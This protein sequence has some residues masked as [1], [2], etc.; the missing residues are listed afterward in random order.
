MREMFKAE[1]LEHHYRV[2]EP[3]MH[4]HAP[5]SLRNALRSVQALL[6]KDGS[7]VL[8]TV[9][10]ALLDADPLAREKVSSWGAWE[11]VRQGMGAIDGTLFDWTISHCVE[12]ER[13][14]AKAEELIGGGDFRGA[15][16]SVRS[17]DILGA[18]MTDRM[19]VDLA[20][21][22]S[23]ADSVRSRA[24]AMFEFQLSQV[25]S[26]EV[27]LQAERALLKVGGFLP[28]LVPAKNGRCRPGG[29]FLRWLQHRRSLP[30]IKSVLDYSAVRSKAGYSPVN[31]ATLKRW[32]SGTSFP[33]LEKLKALVRALA[34]AP[35]GEEPDALE[36]E[37]A[38]Y[39]FWAAR[40]FNLVLTLAEQ[41]VDRDQAMP[42]S[43]RL[44]H[45]LDASSLDDWCQRRYA[46]WLAY[47]AE[48]AVPV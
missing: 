9:R 16:A 19:A 39:Q 15:A 6:P 46:W 21:A 47:W 36:L 26:V 29:E 35:G 25:A 28:L 33:T 38:W 10:S 20:S 31:E 8:K 24:A 23:I 4:G 1:G 48:R 40:R 43:R 41:I 30:T 34:V 3:L 13:A 18:Y 14:A 44:L 2:V 7:D 17:S 37:A 27:R 12:V 32:S 42:E 11:A 5:E 22:Q 45:L